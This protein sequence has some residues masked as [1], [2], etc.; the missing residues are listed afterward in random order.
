MRAEAALWHWGCGV[1]TVWQPKRCGEG[2]DAVWLA[3]GEFSIPIRTAWAYGS[4][5]RFGVGGGVV[6]DSNPREEYEETLHKGR[7]LVRCLS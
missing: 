1:P 6:W 3:Q 7:S 5:L 2:G 4:V